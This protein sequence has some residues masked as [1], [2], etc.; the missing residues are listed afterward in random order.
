MCLSAMEFPHGHHSHT[1]HDQR[2][3][4]EEERREHYPPPPSFHQPPPYY[5]ENELEPSPPSSHYYQEPPQPPRPYFQEANYAPL[6][7]SPFQ[8]TQVVR[9]FY[10]QVGDHSID[11]PP[12][13]TQVNHVSHEKIEIH[14]SFKPRLPYSI[15]QHAHQSGSASGIDLCSNFKVYSKAKPDFHLTIRDGKVILAPSNPSDEFQNWF[16]DEKYST[17]VKDS[18]GCPA[19]AVVNKATGQAIKHSIGEAHPDSEGCP[20][21]AVVN[22]ATGQAIK[23]SIG[24]AYP[25]Q[26][27]P[28]NPDVLDVSILWTESKDLGNGFRAVRMVNNIHLNVDA[29]GG[30][31]KS[32]GV[33]DGT[34]IGLWKWN[35]GDNQLWKIIPA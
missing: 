25:V 21:F 9:T 20:A 3:D 1:H 8:E 4:D 18:E 32:G 33:H 11:Y 35:E 26:L 30:D 14:L 16:K 28:Y 23:H 5:G 31:T 22:K 17:R 34:T 29:F 6:P 10:H 24:E 15:H 19:F 2:N 13:Q 12:P 7:P 27:I